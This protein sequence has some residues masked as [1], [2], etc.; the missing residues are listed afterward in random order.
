MLYLY[1][2]SPHAQHPE[3]SRKRRGPENEIFD[4]INKIWNLNGW[5]EIWSEGSQDINI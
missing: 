3:L 5:A 4:R 2:T 1:P